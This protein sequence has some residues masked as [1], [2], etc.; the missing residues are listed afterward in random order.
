MGPPGIEPGSPANCPA[1][2]KYENSKTQNP[3]LEGYQVTP[4]PLYNHSQILRVVKLRAKRD[5]ID[6]IDVYL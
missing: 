6:R 4:R 1:V 3:K 5:D 2:L